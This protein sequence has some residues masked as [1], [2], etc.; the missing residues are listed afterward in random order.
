MPLVFVHISGPSLTRLS[1][2]STIL[3]AIRDDEAEI[4]YIISEGKPH[5][6]TEP[7]K[8]SKSVWYYEWCPIKDEIYRLCDLVVMRAGHTAISQAIQ[9]G[10]PVVTI[11]IQ[12]QG[13]QLGNA[14]KVSKLGIGI[15]LDPT[16]M[17]AHDINSTIKE[18]L[19]NDNYLQNTNKIKLV[20]E[21]MNGIENVINI[22]CSYF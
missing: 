13:E 5:G 1:L 2:I 17:K 14:E 3:E 22:I 10:K 7:T 21:E 12:N 20:A 9:Y 6:K 18:V 4:Q 19:N 8:I 15:K 16:S 11:P